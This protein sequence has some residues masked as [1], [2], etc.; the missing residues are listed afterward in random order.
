MEK[1]TI[2]EKLRESLLSTLKETEPKAGPEKKS[3]KNYNKDYSE[4]QTKL[5]NTM[6]KQSQ[7]MAAAGLGDPNNATDRSLFS[8][9]VRKDK[10]DEGGQYL[11]DD[12]E[13]ASVIKVLN[14]PAAYLNVKKNS[15]F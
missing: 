7:V 9:K 13:L 12:R 1:K 2:K 5:Q 11:F 14:N 8:K 15:N 3:N 10:N 4:V 6:L